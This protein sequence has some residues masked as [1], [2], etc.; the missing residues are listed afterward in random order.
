[1]G[2]SISLLFSLEHMDTKLKIGHP[3]YMN[4][5]E[6]VKTHCIRSAP[7]TLKDISVDCR[8]RLGTPKML[9]KRCMQLV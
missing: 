8:T 7:N 3:S 1:M 6:A 2:Q 5:E 4:P 9:E